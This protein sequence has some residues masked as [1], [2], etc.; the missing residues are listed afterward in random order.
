MLKRREIDPEEFTRWGGKF[1][2]GTPRISRDDM[3][4]GKADAVFQ[5][6]AYAEA[7]KDVAR[8]RPLARPQGG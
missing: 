1:L 8:Q 7:W 3:V 6:G 4:S 2:E 5:E